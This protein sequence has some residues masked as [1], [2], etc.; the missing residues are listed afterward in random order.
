MKIKVKRVLLFLAVVLVIGISAFQIIKINSKKETIEVP[1]PI[2]KTLKVAALNKDLEYVYAGV[3]KSRYENQ[4]AFQIGGKIIKKNVEVG[5]RVEEGTVL[6]EVDYE[7]MEE[8]VKNAEAS[9]SAAESKYKLAEDN[10]KRYEQLYQAKA[11]T[12]AEYDNYV[13]IDETAKD[14]LD[15]GNALYAQSM[16]QLGY[17]KLYADKA[18]VV[19]S[20]DAEEGQVVAAGQKIVTLVQNNELEVEINVPENRIDKLKSAKEIDVSL[21]ALPSIK[22]KGSV[23]EISP[24]ANDASRTYRVRISLINPP[25]SIKIGMSSNVSI[26][27][28]NS[29]SKIWIPIAAVYQQ[30]TAP[31]VWVVNENKVSLKNITL[32]DSSSDQITVNDGLSE[33]DEVVT[34]G[35]TKL[36]EG[37]EVRIGSD[38]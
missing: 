2:V 1:P 24:V 9:V 8:T 6:M 28:D 13:N 17:C 14:A 21:W 30:T 3:V 4:L 12:Q 35:V 27:E 34:A 31:A 23:R 11:I 7:N 18:G 36:R 16:N 20:V 29:S 33:G 37:Q 10:L 19:S 25:S 15:Q 26:S 38:S 22:V 32:G 5:D